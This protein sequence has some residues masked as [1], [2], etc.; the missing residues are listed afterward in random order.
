M[1]GERAVAIDD[2]ATS[3]GEFDALSAVE[4][5]DLCEDINLGRL[6]LAGDAE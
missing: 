6:R 1:D 4:I 5:D 2:I 3:G